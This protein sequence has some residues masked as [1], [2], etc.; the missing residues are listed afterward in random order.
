MVCADA[1]TEGSP[2]RAE[3]VLASSVS[4]MSSRQKPSRGPAAMRDLEL[5]VRPRGNSD[6]IQAFTS[7][8]RIDAELYATEVG[9]TVELLN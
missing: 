4:E 9:A 6:G 7:A 1:L 3:R 5:L 8:E 2:I